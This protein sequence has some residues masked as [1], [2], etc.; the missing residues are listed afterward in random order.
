MKTNVI[1]QTAAL[2]NGNANRSL[3]EGSSVYVR[4]IKNNGNNS[5]TVAFAGGRYNI[6]SELPLNP[7]TDFLTT[8]KFY[9]VKIILASKDIK[10][11]LN[12][13]NLK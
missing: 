2:V 8:V 7:E 9:A 3:S 5:F 4:V 12:A 1:V 6:K 10:I 13:I 11:Q